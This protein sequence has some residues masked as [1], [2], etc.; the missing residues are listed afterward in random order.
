MHPQRLPDAQIEHNLLTTARDSVGPNVPIQPLDLPA[1]TT[2]GI[3]EPTKD[4]T[5]LPSTELEGDSALRL[6]AR[7]RAPKLK[8]GFRLVHL[9]ALVD[10]RFEPRIRGFDLSRHVRELEPDDGVV[11]EFCAEGAALVG[12]FHAFF[13]AD[14]REAEALDDY[15]DT[16]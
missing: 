14:A 9:L 15:A 11:D 2:T 13:V 8:H 5:R 3:A 7:N 1:L 6:Q 12:V 4:L 10:E 16:F